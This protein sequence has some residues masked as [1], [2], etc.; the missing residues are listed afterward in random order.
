ME[1]YRREKNGTPA[2]QNNKSLLDHIAYNSVF[3]FRYSVAGS[4]LDWISG[5]VFKMFTWRAHGWCYNPGVCKMPVSL[6]PLQQSHRLFSCQGKHGAMPEMQ[7]PDL[8]RLNTGQSLKYFAPSEA[9]IAQ[10]DLALRAF[11][12]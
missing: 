7:T 11:Y 10:S 5:M 12:I 8:L 3:A 6:L 9:M 1:E 4:W 2:V